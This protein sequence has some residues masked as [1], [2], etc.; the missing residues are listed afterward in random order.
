MNS[1]SDNSIDDDD[2]YQ[3]TEIQF[4]YLI[5]LREQVR[6]NETI[7]KIGKTIQ[8][9]NKRLNGYPKHSEI[10]MFMQVANCNKAEKNIMNRFDQVFKNQ[11][12]YGRE[13]YKGDIRLMKTMICNICCELEWSDVAP[14]Q[15]QELQP[16]QVQ[17][18]PPVQ[19]QELSPVQVQELSPVQ[20][21][22]LPI[23]NSEI[24]T[25]KSFCKYLY[26]TKP[27]WY[28]E[29]GFV[30]F[31][32]IDKAYRQYFNDYITQCMVLSRSLKSSL[33]IKTARVNQ[34]TKKK[35]VSYST[36]KTMF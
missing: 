12:Q 31:D 9:P 30:S 26:E 15:S 29:N 16:V 32:L 1:S 11:T 24:K 34:I 27:S 13:Y 28:V 5:R 20:V 8:T 2:Y 4:V 7:Y 36:L 22:E 6:L 3:H 23:I 19:I 18:L 21:Q 25:I 14:V 33:F 35:L 10:Y 17:E